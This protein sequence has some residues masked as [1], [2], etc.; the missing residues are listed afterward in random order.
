MSTS[1]DITTIPQLESLLTGKEPPFEVII[2]GGGPAGLTAG[3]Y[4]GR[5]GL[6]TLLIERAM[7]GGQ[8]SLCSMI[9]NYPGFPSGISGAELAGRFEDHAKKFG[10]EIVW[11]EVQNITVEGSLKKVDL[12]D[13]SFAARAVIIATGT[14]PK[15][16]GIPGEDEFRGMGVSYCATCDGAF[17]KDKRIAVIGGGNS[18]IS[19]ALFLTRFASEVCIVHR[20]AALRADKIL[21]DRAMAD[22][23]IDIVWDCVPKK[24]TG[25]T[26][27]EAL[28]IENVLTKKIST[29]KADGVFIYIGEKPNI[30]IIKGSVNLSPDGSIIVTGA[31]ETSKDG[32]FAAGDVC[33]KHLRQIATAAGD[34]AVAADSA[35]KYLE[36]ML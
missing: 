10:V 14:E 3:L 2:I 1:Q 5:A 25:A 30:S 24:I 6:R 28:E 23:K 20:R 16:L 29:I 13:K 31:M 18:A 22:P 4:C 7:L 36:N 19:E 15:K 33:K 32:I 26:S 12:T 8:V 27:V 9:E 21:A 17:Y 11:G 34:G 35:R